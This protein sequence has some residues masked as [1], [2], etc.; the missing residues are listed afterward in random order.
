MQSD[1]SVGEQWIVPLPRPSLPPS[2]SL[3][4]HRLAVSCGPPSLWYC[5]HIGYSLYPV[6]MTCNPSTHS[7]S[8][9]STSS[10]N[11]LPHPC[12]SPV[13]SH[14]MYT[15]CA[16]DLSTLF[17]VKK[18]LL[19][20]SP[21]MSWCLYGIQWSYFLSDLWVIPSR[22]WTLGSVGSMLVATKTHFP[23]RHN[24]TLFHKG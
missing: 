8:V 24:L 1:W 18:P 21:Y 22:R 17:C 3:G 20:R 5:S 6:D 12:T 2:G 4:L 10:H 7:C 14:S 19:Q 13:L 11:V 15:W 23:T 9:S 16:D